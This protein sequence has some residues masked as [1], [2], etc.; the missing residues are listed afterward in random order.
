[1][2]KSTKRK[3]YTLS[4]LVY[5]RAEWT[6]ISDEDSECKLFVTKELQELINRCWRNKVNIPDA[7]KQVQLFL[8]MMTKATDEGKSDGKS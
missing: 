4:V 7:A 8:E 6:D 5:Y 1:M 2:K 3:V